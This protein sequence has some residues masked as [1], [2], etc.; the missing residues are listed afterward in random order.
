[1]FFLANAHKQFVLSDNVLLQLQVASAALAMARVDSRLVADVT[2]AINKYYEQHKPTDV[3]LAQ[4]RR[5]Q[6]HLEQFAMSRFGRHCR[7][8]M[9]GSSASGL[10]LQHSD[11]DFT[12]IV[13]EQIRNTILSSSS[14]TSSMSSSS[15]SGGNNNINDD[16]DNEH[17]NDE[18]DDDDDDNDDDSEEDEDEDEQE[19]LKR[20]QRERD[21]DVELL[22]LL[23]RQLKHGERSSRFRLIAHARVPII[24][25]L[26]GRGQFNPFKFE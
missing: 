22:E 4:R 26:V 17:N 19:I 23:F 8:E 3:H 16:N 5:C 12:L 11:I 20:E 15:N 2:H 7:V 25:C 24:Q 21:I 18:D 1:M 14:T 13:P 9:F 6:S 10:F